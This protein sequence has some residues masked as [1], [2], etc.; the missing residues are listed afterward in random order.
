MGGWESIR[1]HYGGVWQA[2]LDRIALKTDLIIEIL[3][4]MQLVFIWLFEGTSIDIS[5]KLNNFIG[6][7]R[8]SMVKHFG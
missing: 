1:I 5:K 8:V 6:Y 2:V 3:A 4:E 7:Y